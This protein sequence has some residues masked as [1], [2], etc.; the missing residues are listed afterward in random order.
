M[1]IH[2]L[3]TQ[4]APYTAPISWKLS[5]AHE[6]A[7]T[8]TGLIFDGPG[9]AYWIYH[10]CL[11][12]DGDVGHVF[13]QVPSYDQIAT[14]AIQWL[15]K[16]QSYGLKM[17][18]EPV[19]PS[20]PCITDDT[21]NS[22][23]IFFDGALP[24]EKLQIRLGRVDQN[25]TLLWRLRNSQPKLSIQL[26][27]GNASSSHMPRPGNARSVPNSPFIVPV[28]LEALLNSSFKSC[29]HVVSGEADEF[30][31]S[32]NFCS[33]G[34]IILTGDSDLVIYQPLGS[35]VFFDDINEKITNGQK[36]L[37]VRYIRPMYFAF[38][39][40]VP[41]LS[42]LAYHMTNDTK[43]SISKAAGRARHGTTSGRDKRGLVRTHK[44]YVTSK[45][46]S[47]DL[48]HQR[49][50]ART[51]EV[52][53]KLDPRLSELMHA[54]IAQ[55]AQLTGRIF[56]GLFI[57]DPS[58]F[59]AWGP[60]QNIRQIAYSI[61]RHI[62]GSTTQIREIDRR[63]NRNSEN[64]V[65]ILNV[66]ACEEGTRD[67]ITLLEAKT[68]PKTAFTGPVGPPYW[69]AYAVIHVLRWYAERSALSTHMQQITQL[70]MTDCSH[71]TWFDLHFT[72]QI[73]G[74]LY[75]LRILKQILELVFCSEDSI[76]QTRLGK[77]A[78]TMDKL[79][80]I[81]KAM[82][83]I[84]DLMS[85]CTD[86]LEIGDCCSLVGNELA[87]LTPTNAETDSTLPED[88]EK[89][90]AVPAKGDREATSDAWAQH[91]ARKSAY[92]MYSVL[93]DQ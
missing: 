11:P 77:A 80:S 68:D 76:I 39:L 85:S 45:Y 53:E 52:F 55:P 24:E 43:S 29:V 61:L 81:L 6:T 83:P 86:V 15:E 9:F 22:K 74:V 54:L 59:S 7:Q 5:D 62:T 20:E 50:D 75:S 67:L 23:Y 78:S 89:N 32:P 17:Y 35:V 40:G 37:E 56:L 69:K 16:F 92:N 63:G 27:K 48:A 51:A 58:T 13:Q 73:S 65:I 42:A 47:K 82:P 30:C 44:K 3:R 14:S 34:D 70:L 46:Q 84:K 10:Q 36:T 21:N 88:T 33:Y 91:K 18:Y 1:G 2:G 71:I 26:G 28:V 38:Q 93:E 66:T 57:E 90:E 25:L 60:S 19:V 31:A 12:T 41:D 64:V 72:A 4:L 87:T 49:Y 8:I 79:H